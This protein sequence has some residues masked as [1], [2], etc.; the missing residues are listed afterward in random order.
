MYF[1][2]SLFMSKVK[3][4]TFMLVN[5]LNM[6]GRFIPMT[7]FFTTYEVIID[8]LNISIGSTKYHIASL[9]TSTLIL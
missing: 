4:D 1:I 3:D 7:K 9:E 2:T 5:R 8:S 6:Y